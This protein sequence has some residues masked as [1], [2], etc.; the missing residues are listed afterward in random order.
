MEFFVAL[1]MDGRGNWISIEWCMEETESSNNDSRGDGETSAAELPTCRTRRSPRCFPIHGFAMQRRHVVGIPATPF[2]GLDQ[3]C[4]VQ[5]TG[6]QQAFHFRVQ[7]GS[8]AHGARVNDQSPK[9][10]QRND[11]LKKEEEHQ[12]QQ[13]EMEGPAVQDLPHEE[14]HPKQKEVER[15]HNK[16]RGQGTGILA[17]AG[18]QKA[19]RVRVGNRADHPPDREGRD[20]TQNG[21]AGRQNEDAPDPEGERPV[22]RAAHGLAHVGA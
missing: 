15:T 14:N 11:D 10:G 18:A 2:G 3:E 17:H 13:D 4:G 8:L 12:A 16:A 20:E 5:A 19:V 22:R 9:G 1:R 6:Q 21:D 7:D